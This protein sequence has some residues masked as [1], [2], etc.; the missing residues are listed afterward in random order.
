MHADPLLIVAPGL[1]EAMIV[2]HRNVHFVG[3]YHDLSEWLWASFLV[4]KNTLT[5]KHPFSVVCGS[6]L[7][8]TA[9]MG[10]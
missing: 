9:G 4:S 8:I 3:S 6:T 7:I 10:W 5:S 1:V 2:P